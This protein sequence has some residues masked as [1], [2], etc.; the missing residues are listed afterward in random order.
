MEIDLIK[1]KIE[2]LRMRQQTKEE[3]ENKQYE[4][5]KAKSYRLR[6]V[7]SGRYEIVKEIQK[8]ALKK[9]YIIDENSFNDLFNEFWDLLMN[10]KI[11]NLKDYANI[12]GLKKKEKIKI[13]LI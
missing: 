6:L 4:T 10:E 9:L 13:D 11:H 12:K 7:E 1:A 5:E 2:M 3:L 8:E